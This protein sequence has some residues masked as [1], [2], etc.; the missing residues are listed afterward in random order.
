MGPTVVPAST[1]RTGRR[2]KFTIAQDAIR[3]IP[4][5]LEAVV[6]FPSRSNEYF[7]ILPFPTRLA[8]LPI[9]IATECQGFNLV[10]LVYNSRA[11]SRSRQRVVI[12]LFRTEHFI[13]A[14]TLGQAGHRF[15]FTFVIF[16]DDCGCPA[17]TECGH[18]LLIALEFDRRFRA[19]CR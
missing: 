17:E 13:E 6:M 16:I 18:Q 4:R 14:T 15:E 11:Y 7:K 12:L 2:A 10:S 5:L 8:A 9:L 1:D 19:D 3:R